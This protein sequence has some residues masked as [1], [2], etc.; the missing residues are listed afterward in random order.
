MG[1]NK[2]PEIRLMLNVHEHTI[3]ETNRDFSSGSQK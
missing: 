2:K 1:E 3:N